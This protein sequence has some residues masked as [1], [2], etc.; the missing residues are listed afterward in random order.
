MKILSVSLLWALTVF[1][2][3]A[4]NPIVPPGVYV[5]D[6]SAHVWKDGK[7]Y[8]YGS[9]DEKPDYYCSW[10]HDVLSSSDMKSWFI[11]PNAF[12]SKGAG[13]EVSY[14]DERLFAPD[15]QF[16]NNR[17]YLFYCLASSRNTEGVA[18]SDS[19]VGPFRNGQVIQLKGVNEI[20]PCVF[21]DDDGQAYYIW[22]QFQAKVAKMKPNLLEIDSSTI[23]TQVVTEKDHFFHE[24]GYMIKRNGIYYFVYADMSRAGRPT[25]IG[26]ATGNSPFGPFTY[27]GVIIDNDRCDPA[28]WNNHG[29]LVEFDGQWYIFYHRATHNSFTMRK[30]CVEP[31]F[32]NPDG[33]INEVE[34][35][36]QGASGPLDPFQK[37][38]AERACLL[39][40]NVRIQAQSEDNE[41][42]AGIK[43]QDKVAY[44]Y[45]DFRSG[46]DSLTVSLMPGM[47]PGKIDIATDTPWGKSIGSITVPANNTQT[48]PIN[49]SC[50][51]SDIKGVHAIWLRFSGQGDDLFKV[52]WFQFK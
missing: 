39:H 19:P 33:S 44:K 29:S 51:I 36:T 28:N 18:T 9:R 2:L 45:F 40:G 16:F 46:V 21:L 3:C 13:D 26:Y 15:C 11:T 23:H 7:I 49:L 47:N 38:D 48:G 30:T 1:Q 5:A 27:R 37:M 22:G 31:I 6:P 10:R 12:A 8:V 50:K 25:C 24:G 35:T 32:F 20:D 52:D 43:H 34:M 41:E 17:Y 14:S 4:Q 42:L